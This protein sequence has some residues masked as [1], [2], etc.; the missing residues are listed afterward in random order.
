MRIGQHRKSISRNAKTRT[1]FNDSD[2][3]ENNAATLRR[4]SDISSD[5]PVSDSG[6]DASNVLRRQPTTAGSNPNRATAWHSPDSAGAGS[7]RPTLQRHSSNLSGKQHVVDWVGNKDGT[8]ERIASDDE[9]GGDARNTLDRIGDAV[10]RTTA[11]IAGVADDGAVRLAYMAGSAKPAGSCCTSQSAPQHTGF[12]L[13]LLVVL[14]VGIHHGATI[15][16]NLM[17]LVDTSVNATAAA[18][19][20]SAASAAAA[21]AASEAVGEG[22]EL[23]EASGDGMTDDFSFAANGGRGEASEMASA[24]GTGFGKNGSPSITANHV[25]SLVVYG[26][27]MLVGTSGFKFL[28]SKMS[29]HICIIVTIFVQLV[30]SLLWFLTSHVAMVVISRLLSG[31]AFGA[32]MIVACY[33]PGAAGVQPSALQQNQNAPTALPTVLGSGGSASAGRAVGITRAQQVRWAGFVWFALGF[34]AFLGAILGLIFSTVSKLSV[35]PWDA[36]ESQH[37]LPALITLIG[38]VC[39][40]CVVQ[41]FATCCKSISQSKDLPEVSAADSAAAT[42]APPSGAVPLAVALLAGMVVSVTELALPFVLHSEWDR[43]DTEIQGIV[44]AL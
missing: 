8:M 25:G 12:W 13:T 1:V 11:T 40:C 43:S 29:V 36:V 5:E 21:A 31:F 16:N 10:A 22:D 34:G 20:A 37:I 35:L 9:V 6:D 14:F 17:L 3:D 27:G 24:F 2:S 23:A 15:V 32:A 18:S 7:I 19:A 4:E 33:A 30:G 44:V 28:A 42:M 38:M 41:F 26:L 39:I